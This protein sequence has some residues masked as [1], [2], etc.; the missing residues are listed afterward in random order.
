MF[1]LQAASAVNYRGSRTSSRFRLNW[2]RSIIAFAPRIYRSSV[3]RQRQPSLRRRRWLS[4]GNAATRWAGS[5]GSVTDVLLLLISIYWPENIFCLL[6]LIFLTLSCDDSTL[7]NLGPY[8]IT[9]VIFAYDPCNI[10]LQSDF[11]I[12]AKFYSKVLYRPIQT[13]CE[14]TIS[15]LKFSRF[16]VLNWYIY[17]TNRIV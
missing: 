11:Q 17:Y 9:C 7:M 13:P 12:R 3:P 8:N 4:T 16:F 6:G 14:R 5:C 1:Y 10:C 15:L 2:G